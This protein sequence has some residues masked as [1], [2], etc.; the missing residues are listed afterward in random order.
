M[1]LVPDQ[2]LRILGIHW[3]CLIVLSRSLRVM[4]ME[5]IQMVNSRIL[6]LYVSI[7]LGQHFVSFSQLLGTLRSLIILNITSIHLFLTVASI[8][9]FFFL[10][11]G[12]IGVLRHR[13]T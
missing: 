1:V 7:S 4:N 3:V 10:K 6:A 11:L 12:I 2:N 5:C 13:S 8:G 9:W